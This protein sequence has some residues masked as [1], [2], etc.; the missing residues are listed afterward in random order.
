MQGITPN[1]ERYKGK[2]YLKQIIYRT[3]G[4]AVFNVNIGNKV[5]KLIFFEAPIDMM[6]YYELHK[7]KLNNVKLISMEGLKEIVVSRY[8]TEYILKRA[9][10]KEN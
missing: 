9:E 4:N 6:S 8:F 5:D 1:K 7:E 2:G 10:N 3:E